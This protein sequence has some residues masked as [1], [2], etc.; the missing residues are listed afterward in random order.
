MELDLETRIER[1]EEAHRALAAQHI[2]LSATCR[3]MLPLI[4][5]APDELQRQLLL[6]YDNQ[7][8]TMDQGGMDGDFQSQVCHSMGR[9]AELIV[10]RIGEPS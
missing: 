8:Q 6:A 10:G 1:L 2:G 5:A 3:A 9:L 4:T 7:V